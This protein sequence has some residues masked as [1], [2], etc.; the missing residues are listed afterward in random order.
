MLAIISD[1]HVQE[2]RFDCVRYRANGQLKQIGVRRNVKAAAFKGLVTRIREAARRRKS[3]EVHLVFAGDVFE[4]HRAPAWFFGPDNHVRP[5]DAIGEDVPDNP[6]RRKVSEILTQLETDEDHRQLWKAIRR[7]ASNRPNRRL[8]VRVHY[9][10]GNHDRLANAW[11]TVRQQVRRMLGMDDNSIAPFPVCLDFTGPA[12]GDYGVRVRHG[13]EYDPPN[14]P[15]STPAQTALDRG[16]QDYL[17]PA[18]GDYVTVDVAMR[19]ALAFR[20]R[21]AQALRG[22]VK[23]NETLPAPDQMRR[24]YLALTEF[25]DVRPASLLT[26]YLAA[27]MGPGRKET[28]KALKP[29]L[30]DVVET[31]VANRF[32]LDEASKHVPA[33]LLRL[34]PGLVKNLSAPMLED[35]V[36]TLSKA[37]D[38]Q[39][40]S[41]AQRALEEFRQNAGLQLVI[42]GHTHCPEQVPLRGGAVPPDVEAF[43]LNSGTWRTTL[44]HGV[45]GFGRLR[46]ST[47][48][49]CYNTREQQECPDD[50]RTFEVWTGHLAAGT[51]G[52]YDEA[53]QRHSPARSGAMRLVFES[54]EAVAVQK[55]LDG[56][57]LKVSFGV[58]EQGCEAEFE[59]IRAG[60]G[61]RPVS[62]A[63]LW[64]DPN[65]DGDLWFHGVEVDWGNSP[66]NYDDP[67]PWALEP[68]P[69]ES[70]HGQ[71]RPGRHAL[72]ILGRGVGGADRSEFLLRYRIELG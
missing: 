16:W 5:T 39:T 22:L 71:F 20:A 46:A 4:L 8:Q 13:H 27:Q 63:P 37:S 40:D 6:L 10:P 69:R 29:I 45:G 7:F 52:P 15:W 58:D 25:D 12:L 68:L 72:R 9:L 33:V 67:L 11:P 48:I 23:R 14:F 44:P 34:L 28:F 43:Y 59:G 66:L 21:Y 35:I 54:L 2:T 41:P 31:A 24:L 1:L 18:F 53:V 62:I 3:S 32:F 49:F 65:L 51:L 56:A 30:R 70:P 47:M 64:L 38:K 26:E 42:S 50:G 57:E 55:E 36:R 60:A 17:R 19:L 61:P